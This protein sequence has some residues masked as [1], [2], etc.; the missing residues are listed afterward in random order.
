ML[1]NLCEKEKRIRGDW[2]NL[3]AMPELPA[4][5]RNDVSTLCRLGG[6]YRFHYNYSGCW[7]PRVLEG[8]LEYVGRS[9]CAFNMLANLCEKEK[10]IRGDWTNLG[11]MPELPANDLMPLG[12]ALSVP[13]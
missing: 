9:N 8:Q 10:R 4:N 3:G 12:W 1:A 13:L 7:F 2:T 11:A 6:L 5:D